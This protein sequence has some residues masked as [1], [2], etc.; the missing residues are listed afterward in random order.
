MFS[1]FLFCL[2]MINLALSEKRCNDYYSMARKAVRLFKREQ[3]IK[4]GYMMLNQTLYIQ[5]HNTQVDFL[6]QQEQLLNT[7]RKLQIVERELAKEVS[8]KVSMKFI[9]S[10]N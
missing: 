8:N 9:T 4:T 1:I 3:A 5:D 7:E 10:T 6:A 2:S